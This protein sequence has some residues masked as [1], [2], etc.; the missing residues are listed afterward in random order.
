M[1]YFRDRYNEVLINKYSAQF[2]EALEKDEYTPV[3]ARNDEEYRTV[4]A[5][6]PVYKRAMEQVDSFSDNFKFSSIQEQFPRKFPF[7]HFVPKVY[8]QAKAFV[9]DCIQFMEELK[10]AQSEVSDTVRRYSNALFARWSDEL[11]K[12]LADKKLSLIQVG[13]Y[14]YFN[15]LLSVDP[16]HNQHGLSRTLL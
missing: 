11:K 3:T 16:N 14:N 5:E 6:F 9:A 10:L 15:L 7:S 13:F 12:F 1:D 8:G 4:I 2:K